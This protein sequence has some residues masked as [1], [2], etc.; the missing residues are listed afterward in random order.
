MSELK[1]DGVRV[2]FAHPYSAWERGK[3]ACHNRMHRRFI[4]KGKSIERYRCEA[5]LFFADKTNA[6]PRRI[7]SYRTP[8]ELLARELDRTYH[9]TSLKTIATCYYNL[10]F[11]IIA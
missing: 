9:R 3:N 8:E 4:P 5:I 6:L 7:P 2:Y 11:F 1:E 10:R